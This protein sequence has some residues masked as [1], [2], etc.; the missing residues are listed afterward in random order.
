MGRIDDPDFAFPFWVEQVFP[1]FRHVL[2]G[3]QLGIVSRQRELIRHGNGPPVVLHALL[4]HADTA[5]VIGY[6]QFA[7]PQR[8]MVRVGH[9]H[10]VPFRRLPRSGQ[11]DDLRGVP[12]HV[13]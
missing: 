2:G 7:Q 11:T 8:A 9:D 4:V 12:R 5:V 13:T 10:D 6:L 3:K 1:L